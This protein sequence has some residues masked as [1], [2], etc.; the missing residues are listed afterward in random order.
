M[1]YTVS[2]HTNHDIEHSAGE[3]KWKSRKRVF[4]FF[5]FLSESTPGHDINCQSLSFKNEMKQEQIKN[6]YTYIVR[7]LL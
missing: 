1:L 7:S 4:F 6:I 3:A 2:I 5:L